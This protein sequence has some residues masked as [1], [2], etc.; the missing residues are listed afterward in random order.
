MYAG[1]AH[2]LSIFPLSL[3]GMRVSPITSSTFLYAFALAI[4]FIVTKAINLVLHW[5]NATSHIEF[6][7]HN[8][9]Q[10]YVL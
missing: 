9:R 4:V 7:N 6:I 10:R 8:K 1:V 3:R 5:V 2:E